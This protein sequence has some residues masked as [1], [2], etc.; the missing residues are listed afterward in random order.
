MDSENTKS[1]KRK[2]TK[3]KKSA[4]GKE[5]SVKKPRKKYTRKSKTTKEETPIKEPMVEEHEP[6]KIKHVLEFE[7]RGKLNIEAAISFKSAMYEAGILPSVGEKVIWERLDD[8]HKEILYYVRGLDG[9]DQGIHWWSISKN[10][11]KLPE[12]LVEARR[13]GE[14]PEVIDLFKQGASEDDLN[15]LLVVLTQAGTL[16]R[17]KIRN[18][19]FR[20][21]DNRV[22]GRDIFLVQIIWD[23]IRCQLKRGEGLREFTFTWDVNPSK[24]LQVVRKDDWEGLKDVR[25]NEIYNEEYAR[26]KG[27]LNRKYG[28]KNIP[29]T[30]IKMAEGIARRNAERRMAEDDVS[31]PFSEQG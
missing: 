12:A 19:L 8:K 29:E 27:I 5:G 20:L 4:K 23:A 22:E 10:G 2:Y 11:D 25:A 17:Y 28:E 30:A 16:T 14:K 9:F 15:E 31:R 3:R 24:P 21:R 18:S 7:H 1:K 26:Q 6:V 13:K